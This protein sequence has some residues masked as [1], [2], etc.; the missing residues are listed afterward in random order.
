MSL[1]ERFIET[2]QNDSN[3]ECQHYIPRSDSDKRCQHYLNGGSCDLPDQFQCVEWVKAN[4]SKD[5]QTDLGDGES[6]RGGSAQFS[7]EGHRLSVTASGRML[8]HARGLGSLQAIRRWLEVSPA[9]VPFGS[10][11]NS[12]V[13]RDRFRHIRPLRSATR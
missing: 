1:V 7:V 12:S 8:S 9:D 2:V 10:P 13:A 3:Y 5:Q 6:H 4:K 11:T